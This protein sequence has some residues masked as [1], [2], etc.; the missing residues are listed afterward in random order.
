MP[1][2]LPQAAACCEVAWHGTAGGMT[3]GCATLGSAATMGGLLT[4]VNAVKQA[5]GKLL[6]AGE[7][8]ALEGTAVAQKVVSAAETVCA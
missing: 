7:T 5:A 2:N 1:V 8:G 3:L 4:G 6:S